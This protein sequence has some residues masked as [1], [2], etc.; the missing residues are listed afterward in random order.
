MPETKRWTVIIDIGEDNGA[1]RAVARLFAR[2]DDR[3]VGVGI[4]HLNPADRDAPQIGDE[5]ASAR[6]LGELS[7]KLIDTAGADVKQATREPTI[8]RS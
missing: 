2:H 3:L 7:R 4:A 1:T 5:F 8:V 6:A